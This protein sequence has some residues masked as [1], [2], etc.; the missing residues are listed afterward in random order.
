[1]NKT[2]S[3]VI[4]VYNKF[5]FTKSCL[6]DLF[7][8][9][10]NIEIIVIDNNSSDDTKTELSKIDKLNFKYIRNEENIYHSKACN[11]GYALASAPNVLFLNNDIRV[12]EN[13]DWTL[14]ILKYCDDAI[15]GPTMG[16]L[17]N[18]L[19][20]IKEQNKELIGNSYLSGWCIASSKKNWDKL[21][22]GNGQIW[23]EEFPFYYNDTDIGFRCKKAN[24]KLKVI[25]IPVVHFG[26]VSAAQLNVHKLYTDA[27][28]VFIKKWGK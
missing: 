8:L 1:M 17:D 3:I 15:V 7:K 27:R 14:E 22:L 9:P 10:D 12:K 23:N 18:N 5:A 6:N 4:P 28:K 20:F 26:K 19:N 21:D 25:S 24:I 16:L 13:K 2:L 11:Q